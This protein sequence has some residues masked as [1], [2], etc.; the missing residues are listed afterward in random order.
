M[1]K[2]LHPLWAKLLGLGFFGSLVALSLSGC[3]GGEEA[4]ISSA[5]SK[6]QVAENEP[7]A[8]VKPAPLETGGKTAGQTSAPGGPADNVDPFPGAWRATRRPHRPCRPP[9]TGRPYRRCR[10]PVRVRRR[11]PPSC[12]RA[13]RP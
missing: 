5:T 4:P 10:L 3:G 2:V 6:Y 7:N 8:P 12:R 13:S 11:F 1:V 9:A